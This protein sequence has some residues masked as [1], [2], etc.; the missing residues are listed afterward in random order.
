[1]EVE[2]KRKLNL[3][4]SPD[5]IEYLQI[6][7][8]EYGMSISAYLTMLVCN[9]RKE[10]QALE[11]MQNM[12]GIMQRLEELLNKQENNIVAQKTLVQGETI[13]K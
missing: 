1:M 4:V 13:K 2:K 6:Q 10:S 8:T 3:S 9:H 12:G 5:I 7:S 11:S